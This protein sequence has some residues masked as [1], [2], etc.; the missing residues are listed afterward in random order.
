MKLK[1]KDLQPA[2]NGLPASYREWWDIGD[3]Y[4]IYVSIGK[5]VC[6]LGVDAP[7]STDI[8]YEIASLLG[9]DTSDEDLINRN[10]SN[11]ELYL[12]MGID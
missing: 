9:I 11:E 3:G 7:G 6:S 4:E 12:S 5:E 1:D 2:A 8:T 10:K